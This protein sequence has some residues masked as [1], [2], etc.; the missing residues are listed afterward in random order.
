[1]RR[2]VAGVLAT[3]VGA[4]TSLASD[5]ST[6]V[7]ASE[8]TWLNTAIKFGTLGAALVTISAGVLK[9]H[10]DIRKDKREQLEADAKTKQEERHPDDIIP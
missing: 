9:M 7:L 4:A 1:M 5:I 3:W 10:L 8:P 6:N 2:L